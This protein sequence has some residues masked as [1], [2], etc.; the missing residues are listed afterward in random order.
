MVRRFFNSGFIILLIVSLGVFNMRSA[1]IAAETGATVIPAKKPVV[2][3]NKKATAPAP[4]SQVALEEATIL[5]QEDTPPEPQTETSSSTGKTLLYVGAGAAVI[6]GAALAI[7]SMGS[8]SSSTT[9]VKDPPVGADLDGKTWSGYLDLV[10]GFK[11]NVTATVSQ[12]GA[13][14]EITTSTTQEYGKKFVGVISKAAFIKVEDQ[15]TGET[16]S[17]NYGNATWNKIVIYDY[18]HF[19]TALDKLYLTRDSKQ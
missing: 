8:S 19:Y 13:A 3:D 14:L 11:E 7:G 6:A 10:D 9:V 18:V 1:A 4:A 16:W 5:P 17:T 2:T 15:T 12:N